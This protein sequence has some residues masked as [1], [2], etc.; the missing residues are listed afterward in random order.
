MY[1]VLKRCHP[2][3]ILVENGGVVDE[4]MDSERDGEHTDDQA[5]RLVLMVGQHRWFEYRWECGSLLE[6][7]LPQIEYQ[8]EDH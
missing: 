8:E 3:D 2:F 4:T 1:R 6:I 5:D 7:P